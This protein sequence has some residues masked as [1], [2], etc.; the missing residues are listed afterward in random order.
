MD[1]SYDNFKYYCSK[2]YREDKHILETERRDTLAH[3]VLQA[4]ERLE[5]IILRMNTILD[6]TNTSVKDRVDAAR[7]L[8]ETS[9][10]TL[11][12]TVEGPKLLSNVGSDDNTASLE[13][14]FPSD[15]FVKFA[16]AS[17]REQFQRSFDI[18]T[19]ETNV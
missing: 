9:L 13:D 19:G 11:R 5:G 16:E 1:I 2:I 4:K 14:N 12:L 8:I 3:E 10:N 15:E 17:A 6:D 18:K 7:L